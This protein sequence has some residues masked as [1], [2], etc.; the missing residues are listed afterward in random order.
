M[1]ESTTRERMAELE[2]Q[3][4]KLQRKVEKQKKINSVLMSR[5]E[6]S[7]DAQGDAFSLFQTAISLEAKLK[8][9]TASLNQALR[10]IEQT[11]R[12]LEKARD[13]AE[14]ANRAKSEFL[15]NMSHELR[16]PLNAIIGYSEML[17]EEAEDAELESFIPDLQ[18][19]RA[20]GKH[21][22]GLISDILDL[23]KIEA[24]KMDVFLE[25]FDVATMVR[26]VQSVVEPLVAKN[27]NRFVLTCAEDLGD[28][29]SDII[30]VR[31]TLFNLLSNACKFTENGEIGLEVCRET[32][33]D[34]DAIVFRV[35]DSGI[36]MSEE[37]LGKLFRPFSQADASSTRK[38]GGTGLG[39]AITQ[40]F[41]RMLGGNV[42]VH[43]TPGQGSAFTLRIAATVRAKA[44]SPSLM[45]QALSPSRHPASTPRVLV[46]DDDPRLHEVF[47][48][49]LE[50]AG[51][52]VLHAFGGNRGL[53]MAVEHVPDLITLDVVMPDRDGW[54]VLVELK[55]N[56]KLRH[57]PVILVS[58]LGDRELGLALG[59]A[60][61][62]SKPFDSK[63]LLN[64]LRRHRRKDRPAHVLVVDDDPPTREMLRRILEKEGWQV[65]EAC[66][67]REALESLEVWTPGLMLLDLMMPEVDGFA[68]VEAMQA[69]DEWRT[70]PVVIVTA[71]DLSRVELDRLSGRASKVLQKGKYDRADLLSIVRQRM[72]AN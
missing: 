6:R 18:K 55:K 17:I 38:Y 44:N 35:R 37:Q 40:H 58:M 34:G 43:S 19:V 71:L 39:L 36:G 5:V 8:E 25:D 52:S 41:A 51:F 1:G 42:T 33:S 65:S 32:T 53:E 23:S 57:I 13:G 29:H 49:Q 24:G 2:A 20:A 59:A 11:N 56:P 50:P 69:R 70:I 28:M 16:T 4:E 60:D 64:T 22:L 3:V 10:D 68:V 21:L 45:P 63:E 9:R 12:E 61:Y 72:A 47:D 30:K 27:A 66:N 31:Q 14:A 48:E 67:G 7:M 46:I 54:S 62:V 15:A 26:E